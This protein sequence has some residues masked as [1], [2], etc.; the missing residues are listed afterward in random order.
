[1][2]SLFSGKE[3]Q[4]LDQDYA[5]VTEQTLRVLGR[6]K[7]GLSD[8]FLCPQDP[9]QKGPGTPAVLHLG[10]FLCRFPGPPSYCPIT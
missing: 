3:I 7:V 2:S 4:V 5:K 8:C 10:H 1:M 9:A 6:A